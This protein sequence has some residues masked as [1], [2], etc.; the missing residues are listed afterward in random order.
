ME[1]ASLV[2]NHLFL[3]CDEV[4]AKKLPEGQ[5]FHFHH[6]VARLLFLSTRV[7]HDIQVAIAFLTMRIKDSARTTEGN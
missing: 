6:T 1:A 2:P 4:K 3:V 5:A 7:W